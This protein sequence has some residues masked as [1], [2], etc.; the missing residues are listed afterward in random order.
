M[1]TI[2]F[3]TRCAELGCCNTRSKF[4]SYCL[5]HG[6]RDAYDYK[7]HNSSAKR[8]EFNGKYATKQWSTQRKVQLSA[9]PLCAACLSEGIITAA[10]HVDHVFPWARISEAAFYRN[11]FQSLCASHHSAKTALE[12]RGIFR[13]YGTPSR[14]YRAEDYNRVIGDAMADTGC[15]VRVG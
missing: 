6:G 8:K 9:H 11:I 5:E 2:P 1:P 13:R 7:R 4:N 14:D 12:Q 3:N 15:G 10:E